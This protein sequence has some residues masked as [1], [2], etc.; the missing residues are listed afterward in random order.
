MGS[1]ADR[2]TPADYFMHICHS[3]SFFFFFKP[4]A[5]CYSSASAESYHVGSQALG[6]A[7]TDSSYAILNRVKVH[8]TVSIIQVSLVSYKNL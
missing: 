2:C 5:A 3:L 6:I 8:T 7:G 1:L 4:A